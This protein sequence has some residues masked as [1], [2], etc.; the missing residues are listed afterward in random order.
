MPYYLFE[1]PKTK[2]VREEFFHMNDNKKYVDESGVEWKRIYVAP[3]ASIDTAVD[4][5]NP[6]DFVKA[7]NK[8]GT[9]GDMQDRAG[10][11]SE[12]R[13][14]RNGGIDP[15]R[16]QFFERYSSERAGAVHPEVKKRKAKEKLKK[17]GVDLN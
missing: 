2:K 5:W 17:L 10:E 3:N 11:L 7:T 14:D 4:P 12:K 15:V 9:L 13:A 16:E 6:K 8:P 1:H